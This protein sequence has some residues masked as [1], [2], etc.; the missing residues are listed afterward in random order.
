MVE[1]PEKRL[2]A[3]SRGTARGRGARGVRGRG[4]GGDRG[5]GPAGRP[6]GARVPRGPCARARNRRSARGSSAPARWPKGGPRSPVD[7]A[8]GGMMRWL[9][10]GGGS[11]ACAAMP[12]F[13]RRS[14]SAREAVNAMRSERRSSNLSSAVARDSPRIIDSA[15]ARSPR[16]GGP[17]RF[18]VELDPDEPRREVEL[19]AARIELIDRDGERLLLLLRRVLRELPTELHAERADRKRRARVAR[20]SRPRAPAP[21]SRRAKDRRRARSTRAGS[22]RGAG[23]PR[24]ASSGAC[25]PS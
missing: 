14:A 21:S 6:R 8:L 12:T 24:N 15:T 16:G 5:G 10:G 7:L 2:A 22:R 11:T 25:A 13:A 23:R 3:V 4:G 1:G 19:P 17:A 20:A 9:G 18:A